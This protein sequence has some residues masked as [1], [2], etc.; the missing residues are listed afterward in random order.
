MQIH[1]ERVLY[2]YI[3][4]MYVCIYIYIYNTHTHTYRRLPCTL[5]KIGLRAFQGDGAAE[6]SVAEA[7]GTS[8]P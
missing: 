6:V 8:R 2:I 5:Q 3:Y 1:R 7:A 4:I